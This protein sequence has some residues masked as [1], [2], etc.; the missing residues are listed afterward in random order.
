MLFGNINETGN[1]KV[2]AFCMLFV[3]KEKPIKWLCLFS[4]LTLKVPYYAKQT[5]P[6]F[7]LSLSCLERTKLYTLLLLLA[8]LFKRCVQKHSA[9]VISPLLCHK[10]HRY[11]SQVKTAPASRLSPSET[12]SLPCFVPFQTC[13]T[14]NKAGSCWQETKTKRFCGRL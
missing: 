7:C 4:L 14:N 1:I 12:S 13:G 10:G 9:L 11:L 8:I 3:R 6:M 2:M 5:L